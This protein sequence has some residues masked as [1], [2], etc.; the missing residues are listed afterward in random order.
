MNRIIKVLLLLSVV[1]LSGCGN[2]ETEQQDINDEIEIDFGPYETEF[3]LFETATNNF[4]EEIDTAL[5]LLLE[6]EE[7]Y[8]SDG[9]N[10]TNYGTAGDDAFTYAPSSGEQSIIDEFLLFNDSSDFSDYV[11]LG[12]DTGEF[13]ML[14][15][16]QNDSGPGEGFNYDPRIR[17]WYIKAM[18]SPGE[19]ILNEISG[20]PV[21]DEVIIEENE[22]FITLSKTF[23]D[24]D[25]NII[26]VIG[27]D[28]TKSYF[29]EKFKETTYGEHIVHGLLL[30]NNILIYDHET[31]FL[32][33]IYHAYPDIDL[34]LND[35]SSNKFATSVQTLNGIMYHVITYKVDEDF[36]FIQIVEYSLE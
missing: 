19:I 30:G 7:I 17:S 21:S 32:E 15:P 27:M 5:D 11:Y 14:Y 26:G 8:S 29:I 35:H 24:D 13:I 23:V 33:R 31:Y 36:Y 9:S 28:I 20:A 10:F 34:S 18:A 4:F 16:I 6:N 22:F 1:G 2:T 25:G 3:E 12:F